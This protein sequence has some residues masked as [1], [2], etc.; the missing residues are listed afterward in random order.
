MK[1]LGLV[2]KDPK[3][4]RLIEAVRKILEIQDNTGEPRRKVVIFT[5]YQDTIK[6]IAPYCRMLSQAR[7]GRQRFLVNV[8]LTTSFLIS[9]QVIQGK[10]NV[11]TSIFW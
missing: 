6:H 5:E 8:S 1:A 4:K 9:M 11:M 7:A 3:S 2:A 10:D